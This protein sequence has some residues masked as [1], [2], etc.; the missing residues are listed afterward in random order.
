MPKQRLRTALRIRKSLAQQNT[1]LHDEQIK[2]QEDVTRHRDPLKQIVGRLSDPTTAKA[3][4]RTLNCA[5]G[6]C[7][8]RGGRSLLQLQQR[9]GNRYVQRVLALAKGESGRER[10]SPAVEW[11]VH[12]ARGGEQALDSKVRA[13]TESAF[14][15]D[16]SG[17]RVHTDPE[18]VPSIRLT[19][20]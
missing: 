13:K 11:D 16:F 10:G 20:T 1:G 6:G 3:H 5:T 2:T 18:P 7:P 9:Y 19:P 17:V 14:G 15:A 8:A 12:R 4:A